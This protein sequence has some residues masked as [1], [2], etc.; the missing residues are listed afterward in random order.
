MQAWINHIKAWT[1][2]TLHKTPTIQAQA[3]KKHPHKAKT[4]HRICGHPLYTR[5]SWKFQ[6]ICGKYGIQVWQQGICCDHRSENKYDSQMYN[7]CDARRSHRHFYKYIYT[8]A[9]LNIYTR[10]LVD[11]V[12]NVTYILNGS[13]SCFKFWCNSLHECNISGWACGM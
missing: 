9:C 12:D 13:Y 7:I 2:P 5:H 6:N 10:I 11:Y 3:Q 4:Q 8:H 1:P